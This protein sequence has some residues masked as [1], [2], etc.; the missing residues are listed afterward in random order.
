M[1]FQTNPRTLQEETMPR[2]LGVNLRQ[3]TL[4][5][6]DQQVVSALNADF[7]TQPGS[8]LSRMGTSSRASGLNAPVTF[9]TRLGD[10]I[11]YVGGQSLYINNE[12]FTSNLDPTTRTTLVPF[13]GLTDVQTQLYIANGGTMLRT[14]G[15][16]T[17][18]WGIQ[19]PGTIADPVPVTGAPLNGTYSVRV[20]YVRKH[21]N[22]LIHESNPSPRSSQTL[23]VN[24]ALQLDVVASSDPQVTGI[25]IYRTISN[26]VSHLFEVEVSN[27]S[28][29]V[30]LV[31][32][33]GELGAAV[34]FDNDVPPRASIA[35][36]HRDRI[37]LVG[38]RNV[39]NRVWYTPRFLPDTVP[40]LNFID[41]RSEKDPI[42]SIVSNRGVLSLFTRETK[43]RIIE[44]L[45]GVD[46]IGTNL[47][48]FGGTGASFIPVEAS[49]TRGTASHFAVV[50]T[51]FGTVFVANDGVFITDFQGP[52][53]LISSPIQS[54]FLGESSG[55]FEPINPNGANRMAA[56]FYKG[57]YYLSYP[58]GD[59]LSP[60]RLAI[61][62]FETS[63][64]YFYDLPC[65]A[66][67][68]DE[69]SDLFY[70]GT[71]TGTVNL[72]E[73]P[74]ALGDNGTPIALSFRTSSDS[75][76]DSF[77]RKLFLYLRV[78]AEVPVGATLNVEFLVDGV[79]KL[80]TAITGNRT[81]RLIRLP[82]ATM[83]YTWDVRVTGSTTG[84]IRFHQVKA[85]WLP[86]ST[87]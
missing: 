24:M 82:G 9:I 55:D 15:L 14:D 35:V 46:S 58:A 62:A 7:Y 11:A 20:T 81:R 1:P 26:G 52:D 12:E 23:L 28:Q 3:D 47:P 63:S 27:V 48:F 68:Y 37:W 64:W 65:T 56:A 22:I 53:Q 51:G 8:I 30:T 39:P 43:Y 33:D 49:S 80:T 54:L 66:L 83:G 78:D 77:L 31:K 44:Q 67:Y 73:N 42:T 13:R 60:N 41:L 75:G 2:F 18:D 34:G 25:R 61:Y 69:S 72:I 19:P 74:T 38:D 45:S 57:R 76:Q 6:A 85:T 71:P 17:Y 29:T 10:L 50:P 21:G 36:E 59:T 4:S 32:L 70:H 16:S 84:R 86:L 40:A 79:S 5:T 87:A